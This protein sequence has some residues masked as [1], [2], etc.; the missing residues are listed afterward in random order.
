M[1]DMYLMICYWMVI[2]AEYPYY[3]TKKFNFFWNKD[4]IST[5]IRYLKG[6]VPLILSKSFQTQNIIYS[7]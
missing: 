7:S 6:K 1:V 3:I 2:S 4:Q 5:S